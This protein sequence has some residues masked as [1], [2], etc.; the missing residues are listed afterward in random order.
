[1]YHNLNGPEDEKPGPSEVQADNI[2]HY[3]GSS[4]EKKLSITNEE[5]GPESLCCQFR[6]HQKTNE[7]TDNQVIT[8]QYKFFL[9]ANCNLINFFLH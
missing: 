7:E 9:L 1:M 3:K 6:A 2:S 8:F 5:I 4:I